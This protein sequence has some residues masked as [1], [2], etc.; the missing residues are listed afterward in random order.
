MP[1][2]VKPTDFTVAN[3][4]L[5][6]PWMA[7]QIGGPDLSPSAGLETA[8]ALMATLC[9]RC[10]QPNL[11]N[12]FECV[13]TQDYANGVAFVERVTPFLAKWMGP[14]ELVQVVTLLSQ[15]LSQPAYYR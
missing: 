9:H 7:L 10:N 11:T 4:A 5:Q 15:T 8:A 6:I 14:S 3:I 1:E 12:A 13:R 2:P